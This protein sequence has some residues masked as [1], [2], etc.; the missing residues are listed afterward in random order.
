[1]KRILSSKIGLFVLLAILCLIIMIGSDFMDNEF[2]YH[3]ILVEF[4]GLVFDLFIFGIILTI[5]ESLKSKKEKLE[6]KEN[7]R[8]V[9][10]ERYK[11]EINDFRFWKS[12]EA[13][14]RIRGL[15]KRLVDLGEEKINLSH[16][17]LD[18]EKSLSAYKNMK[19]WKFFAANLRNSFF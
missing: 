15:V 3:D 19:G 7:K 2:S 5:Y 14:Y 6:L 9:L 17:Y 16:C 10:I 18:T 12:E 11:E 8:L 13:F 4:H 1:M